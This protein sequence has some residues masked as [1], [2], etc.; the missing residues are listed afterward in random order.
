MVPR[1]F[2]TV[3]S[4]LVLNMQKQLLIHARACSEG[5]KNVNDALGVRPKTVLPVR[6]GPR[7]LTVPSN[8][9]PALLATVLGQLALGGGDVAILAPIAVAIPQGG[10]LVDVGLVVGGG[11]GGLLGSGS[12]GCERDF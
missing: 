3:A 10:G 7:G 6:K 9:V 8:Q 4:A 11:G 12:H 5:K 2:N 1:D